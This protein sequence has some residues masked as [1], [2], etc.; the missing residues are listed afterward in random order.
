ML[1]Y[2]LI[3]VV[4]IVVLLVAVVGL[5]PSTFRVARSASISASPPAVFAHVNDLH[6]W[7]AWSP[8][9]KPLTGHIPMI[10]ERERTHVC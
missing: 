7:D 2:I 5:Q 4:A 8:W 1:P 10:Q 3:A 9:A 6:R